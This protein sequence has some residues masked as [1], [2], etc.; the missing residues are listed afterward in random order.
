MKNEDLFY[1][2]SFLDE[3]LIEEANKVDTKAVVTPVKKTS[4]P[5]AR[6]I[7]LIAPWIAAAAALLVVG[8]LILYGTRAGSTSTKNESTT[9]GAAVA[10]DKSDS[11]LMAEDG[12]DIVYSTTRGDTANGG[13]YSVDNNLDVTTTTFPINIDDESDEEVEEPAD[14]AEAEG[15]DHALDIHSY[16]YEFVYGEDTYIITD[17][18][19]AEQIDDIRGELIGTVTESDVEGLAD[20]EIYEYIG[21]EDQVL[22][23]YVNEYYVAMRLGE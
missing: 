6:V 2:M 16:Q 18:A 3:D 22:V 4:K 23:F 7:P 20:Q 8:G 12:E 1:A 13:S 9:A 17:Y 5:K 15:S 14:A 19:P 11:E 10:A 21:E